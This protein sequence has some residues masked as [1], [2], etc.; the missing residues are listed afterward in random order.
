M[1]RAYDKY[2]DFSFQILEE[3]EPDLVVAMEQYWMNMLQPDL[4]I[5]PVAGSRLGVR[6][7]EATKEKQRGRVVSQETRKKIRE[8]RLLQVLSP[9]VL[10]RR[11]TSVR[12]RFNTPVSCSNGKNY[13]SVKEASSD[14]GVPSPSISHVLT[15]L[16][17]IS[18]TRHGLNFWYTLGY[19][20]EASSSTGGVSSI[21]TAV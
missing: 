19:S 4:N 2:G 12:A 10:A 13:A 15:G 7:S 11:S 14:T 20:R 6:A 5:L 16:V 21:S 17:D 18:R 9:E 8:A 1:Q 3:W